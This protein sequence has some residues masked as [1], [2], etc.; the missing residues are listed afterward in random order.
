MGR[1]LRCKTLFGDQWAHNLL[2]LNASDERGID[3]I[4]NKVKDFARTRAIAFFGGTLMLGFILSY[5]LPQEQIM[6]LGVIMAI[7]SA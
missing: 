2:E 6:V 1:E 7:I 4:R 3:V 5:S